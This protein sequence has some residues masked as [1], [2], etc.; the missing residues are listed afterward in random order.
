MISFRTGVMIALMGLFSFAAF[1]YTQFSLPGN[2]IDF[3]WA[4]TQNKFGILYS[5]IKG[6]F[7]ISIYDAPTERLERTIDLEQY[8]YRDV[9]GFD[10]LPDD[11]GLVLCTRGLLTEDFLPLW[12]KLDLTTGRTSIFRND[13]SWPWCGGIVMQPGSPYYGGI[14]VA[15]EVAEIML[16]DWDNRQ[17][18]S[19]IEN[20]PAILLAIRGKTIY[21]NSEYPLDQYGSFTVKGKVIS[22]SWQDIPEQLISRNPEKYPGG[23][24]E[25]FKPFA[26]YEINLETLRIKKTD[27]FPRDLTNTSADK[28]YYYKIEQAVG[29]NGPVIQVT[30]W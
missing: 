17:V 2:L 30:L 26:I 11:S 13:F 24:E 3:E 10:W 25:F 1:G 4:S 29:L 27:I 18:F 14:G 9:D 8:G 22:L 12:V 19:F 6:A 15:D 7:H 28:Q 21:I 16:F 23:L 20:G 5:D